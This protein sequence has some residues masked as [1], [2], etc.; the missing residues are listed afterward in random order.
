[1]HS[2]L[3]KVGL[4]LMYKA[5]LIG[6]LFASVLFQNGQVW[7][8]ITDTA[9]RCLETEYHK[10]IRWALGHHLPTDRTPDTHLVLPHQPF[11]SVENHFRK[12][13]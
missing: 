6:S 2:I 3:T 13:R 9:M 8:G 11:L 1:M 10:A 7:T 4:T 12:Q 5:M